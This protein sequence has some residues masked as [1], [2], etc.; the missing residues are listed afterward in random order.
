[1]KVRD[2]AETTAKGLKV[3]EERLADSEDDKSRIEVEAMQARRP[4]LGISSL[5]LQC[6]S[7]PEESTF[8]SLC[9]V[10]E[11]FK[12]EML[13]WEEEKQRN[14]TIIQEYKAVRENFSCSILQ[15]AVAHFPFLSFLLG[16]IEHACARYNGMWSTGCMLFPLEQFG[17]Q[18]SF[19][20]T[21]LSLGS[22]TRRKKER[23]CAVDNAYAYVFHFSCMFCTSRY[24]F[25]SQICQRLERELNSGSPGKNLDGSLQVRAQARGPDS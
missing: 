21:G 19:L 3:A 20:S 2:F 5:R 8:F 7:G 17:Q 11:M 22:E 16:Y 18:I 9:Q 6:G 13:R 15:L 24:A 14:L 25:E 10:K 1:L 4:N 23:E 12:K